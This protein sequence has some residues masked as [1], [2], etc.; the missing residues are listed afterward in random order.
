MDLNVTLNYSYEKTLVKNHPRNSII[1][2]FWPFFLQT[3]KK[4]VLNSLQGHLFSIYFC[5]CLHRWAF[6]FFCF[7]VV[8][9]LFI[10]GKFWKEK[11]LI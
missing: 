11:E 7:G 2:P 6:S 10:H 1:L 9:T 5:F 8:L 3:L 4:Y